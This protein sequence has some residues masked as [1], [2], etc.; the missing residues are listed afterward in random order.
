[1]SRAVSLRLC[2]SLSSLQVCASQGRGDPERGLLEA[3]L[4]LR[5]RPARAAM[6]C[7]GSPAELVLAPRSGGSDSG[8]GHQAQIPPVR[9]CHCALPPP[10]RPPW[11]RG[12]VVRP[13]PWHQ[14]TQTHGV[15]PP[16]HRNVV[17]FQYHIK[18]FCLL[19]GGFL[20]RINSTKFKTHLQLLTCA[21]I[22]NEITACKF[23][24]SH[25]PRLPTPGL[26]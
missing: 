23:T 11:H 12:S 19:R 1:M 24:S 14:E 20:P 22:P 26:F 9:P 10:L 4:A 6:D 15:S 16:P 5:E 21:C 17:W 18:G 8:R 7:S 13:R 3:R 2:V 25:A